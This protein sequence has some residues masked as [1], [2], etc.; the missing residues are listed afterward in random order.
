[1]PHFQMPTRLASSLFA[2]FALVL[3]AC[4]SPGPQSVAPPK[5][6]FQVDLGEG[7]RFD[8]TIER[9]VSTLNGKACYAFITGNVRNTTARTLSRN[10]ILDVIVM[11]K[12]KMSF[13][14]LTNPVADIPPG[15]SA[16]IRM[17]DSPVHKD[18][19]PDYE[20]ID[21]SLRKTFVN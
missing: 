3:G 14:D 6:H 19:C 16:M 10:S 15:G 12:G 2:L 4:S 21:V 11:E 8:Y 17:V 1:M 13:R 5:Q 20:R 18:G 7:L 9:K